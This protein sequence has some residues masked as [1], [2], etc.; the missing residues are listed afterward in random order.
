MWWGTGWWEH[1]GVRHMSSFKKTALWILAAEVVILA[2][3]LAAF[4]VPL[5]GKPELRIVQS[6]SMELR[7]RLARLLR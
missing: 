1:R 7:C 2:L 3:V 6:G 4:L 5:P